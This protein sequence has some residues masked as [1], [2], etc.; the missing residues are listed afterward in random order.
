MS[1]RPESPPGCGWL[2]CSLFLWLLA[3]GILKVTKDVRR[4]R[5]SL[6]VLSTL[7]VLTGVKGW[8]YQ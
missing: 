8:F 5:L 2:L 4:H 6:D 7:A 3:F 1:L